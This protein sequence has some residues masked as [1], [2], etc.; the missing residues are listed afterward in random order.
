[1]SFESIASYLDKF[2]TL[3]PPESFVRDLVIESVYAVCGITLKKYEI[4]SKDRIVYITTNPIVK[5]E[6]IQKRGMIIKKI[7]EKA[8]H[9]AVVE[10]R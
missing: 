8:R 10:I 4:S 7:T 2:T 9:S 1:M 5:N 3:K 6:I